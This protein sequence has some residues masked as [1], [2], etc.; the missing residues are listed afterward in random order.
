MLL[1]QDYQ[2]SKNYRNLIYFL[3]VTE[4]LNSE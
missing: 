3:I 1:S 2:S 4:I